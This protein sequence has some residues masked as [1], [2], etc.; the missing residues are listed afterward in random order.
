MNKQDFA[1]GCCLLFIVGTAGFVYFKL[2]PFTVHEL[3]T[4]S[5][6]QGETEGVMVNVK[7]QKRTSPA[8]VTT[9]PVGSTENDDTLFNRLANDPK[10]KK[11]E[12][13]D[14]IGS[15]TS[16]TAYLLR[17]NGKLFVTAIANMPDAPEG[18][19]FQAW[20]MKENPRRYYVPL[21]KLS[22]FGIGKFI[23]NTALDSDYADFN[24]VI[25]TLEKNDDKLPER[26]V[27]QG[28]AQ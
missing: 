23:T 20:L 18:E 16:G 9:A 10:S 26:F 2:H 28:T 13:K 22:H 14:V 24:A 4:W 5:P 21:G 15:N 7:P 17:E 6:Q 19:Y 25:I 11:V 8:I 12:M 3:L 1:I 27:M